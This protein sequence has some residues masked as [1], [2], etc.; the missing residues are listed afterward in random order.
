MGAGLRR[1]GATA[2]DQDRHVEPQTGGLRAGARL[3]LLG[4]EVWRDD[5]MPRAGCSAVR[6]NCIVYDDKS[7]ASET[8][9]IYS[10]WSMSTRSICCFALT[11][12]V[13]T[14]PLMPFVKQ[15]GLLLMGNFCSR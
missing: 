2:T 10:K 9:A 6:S 4:I 5:S 3:S 7:S 14:A 1:A 15:R 8:P 13:A 12:R 11:R